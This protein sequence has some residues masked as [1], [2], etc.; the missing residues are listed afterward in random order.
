MQVS[1][2]A[3]CPFCIDMNGSQAEAKGITA[4]E[5]AAMHALAAQLHTSPGFILSPRPQLAALPASFTERE[6]L[7][8]EYA[9]LVST[10]P[11]SFPPDFIA[12]LKQ[13]FSEREI[14]ILASTAAQVNYWARL[15]QALGIPPVGYGE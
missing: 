1:Y 9:C 12:E 6:R 10:T 14:V 15:I 5:I 4:D 13:H 11:L 2:A 3:R 8:L 7:A